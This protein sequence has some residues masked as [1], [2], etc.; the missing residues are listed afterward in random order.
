MCRRARDTAVDERSGQAVVTQ[1]HER[2]LRQQIVGNVGDRDGGELGGPSGNA[3][4]RGCNG[5]AQFNQV[6][7]IAVVGEMLPRH[8]DGIAPLCPRN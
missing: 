1:L 5:S 8:V 3:G 4:L 6:P 7:E 2:A